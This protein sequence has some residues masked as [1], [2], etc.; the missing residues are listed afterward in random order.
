LEVCFLGDCKFH[1]F[2]NINHQGLILYAV[3]S[4]SDIVF[5]LF[6]DLAAKAD[7]FAIKV[8]PL[9]TKNLCLC[10]CLSLSVSLSHTHL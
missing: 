1:Q 10:L 2:N 5:A 6:H 3:E 8:S 9:R 7:V 4:G